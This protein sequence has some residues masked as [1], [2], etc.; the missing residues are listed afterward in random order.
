M[1]K[2]FTQ[3]ERRGGDDSAGGRLLGSVPRTNVV[4]P[5]FTSPSKPFF[6][7]F[8]SCYINANDLSPVDFTITW[9]K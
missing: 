3:I 1:Q 7:F 9:S 4:L 8:Y 5:T 2:V 6:S